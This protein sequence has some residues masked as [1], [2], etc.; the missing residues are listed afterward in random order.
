M[1]NPV[2]RG[3]RDALLPAGTALVAALALA[4][5]FALAFESFGAGP[6]KQLARGLW[7]LA[8]AV[9][10]MLYAARTVREGLRVDAGQLARVMIASTGIA[11][12]ASYLFGVSGYLFFPADFLMWSETDYVND[13]IKLRSDH[14]L[15]TADPNNESYTYTPGS[16][17]LTYSLAS[18]LGMGTSLGAL[19]SVQL[20]YTV[21]AVLLAMRG[22]HSLVAL[23]SDAEPRRGSFVEEMGLFSVLFLVATNGLTNPFIHNLH[24]DAL[25]QCLLI[26]GVVLLIDYARTRDRRLF[27]ALLLV[28]AAGFW[29]KQNLALFGGYAVLWFLYDTLFGERPRR[30][31]P[32]V[33]YGAVAFALLCLSIALGYAIWR[34][35]FVYWVFYV[36]SEHKVVP[37]RSVQHIVDTRPYVAVLLAGGF[38]MIRGPRARALLG[39]FGVTA[40]IYLLAAWTGG[41]NFMRHHMGPASTLAAMWLAAGLMQLGSTQTHERWSTERGVRFATL[42]LLMLLLSTSGLSILRTPKATL[43]EDAYRYLEQV[44]AEFETADPRGVL[45]D[46]GSY[47]YL[48]DNIVMKDRASPIGERGSTDTGDL[49]GVAERFA[50]RHYEKLLLRNYRGQNFWYDHPTWPRS[51]GLR[52][53]LEQNYR[54]VRTIPAVEGQEGM[55][56]RIPP[57]GFAEVSVLVPR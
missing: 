11:M 2:L 16:Q 27:V 39:L 6:G 42:A 21:I 22:V 41:I 38:S 33:T 47:V 5:A 36:L 13:I 25:A 20:F 37:T 19:R 9:P 26:G 12:V 51:S 52:E 15:F 44:E 46:L 53:I 40:L 35:D 34:E 48:E 3:W 45:L 54:V 32:L 29:V 24:N 30:F 28:P 18:L 23:A 4:F 57:Y 55:W 17:L 14:P 56:N 7:V 50:N 31:G 1:P 8:I 49:L 43:P 10:P